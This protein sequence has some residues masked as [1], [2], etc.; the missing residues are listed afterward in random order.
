MNRLRCRASLLTS[1]VLTVS[2]FGQSL[3]APER[4]ALERQLFEAPASAL[5]L[6]CEIHPVRPAL[7]FALR[8]ETGYTIDIPLTQ[9]HGA[10][11]GLTVHLRVTPEGHEPVYLTKTGTLPDVP[12][13]NATAE[14]DGAFIVGDGT[15]DVEALVE[16]DLHRSCRGAW[17]IQARR[18][19]GERQLKPSTP[20]GLVAELSSTV[21]QPPDAEPLPRIA[22][23]TV[24]VH[25]APLSPN[26]SK[27]QPGDIQTLGYSLSSL[28]RELPAQSVRLIAFNLDQRA[29]I[30]RRD[31]FEANQI[32]DLQVALQQMDLARVDYRT[33][34]QNPE[35][36]VFVN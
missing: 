15:Y 34:Q 25:A 33:L 4:I 2:A 3:V 30:F 22:R 6:R 10:G 28:L 35:P 17:Q 14:T 1:V 19:G 32:G 21:S 26:L 23:L 20:P 8:F 31:G 13:T 29:I 7:N 36:I 24:L 27:L 9:I 16:D 18:V 11:H 5:Q 12:K